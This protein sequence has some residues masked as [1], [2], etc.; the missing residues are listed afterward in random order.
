MDM[1][2]R[3]QASQT[4]LVDVTYRIEVKTRLK[5]TALQAQQQAQ[6]FL[7][8]NVGNMLSVGEPILLLTGGLVRWKVPILYGLPSKGLLGHIGELLLDVETGEVLLSESTPS[9]IEDLEKRAEQLY[10]T[11]ASTAL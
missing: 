9:S 10:H 5:I 4:D 3:T 1:R 11:T 2:H 8:F 6:T 7:L